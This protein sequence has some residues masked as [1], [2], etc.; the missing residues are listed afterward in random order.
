ML[1]LYDAKASST[2]HFSHEGGSVQEF[3]DLLLAAGVRGYQVSSIEKSKE[4]QI[5][6]PENNFLFNLTVDAQD[7]ASG[8]AVSD[9]CV[10]FMLSSHPVTQTFCTSER[11]Y[12]GRYAGMGFCL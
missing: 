5:E 9:L 12:C 10:T 1:H 4:Y 6:D 2:L 3:A 8:A 11:F 7:Y